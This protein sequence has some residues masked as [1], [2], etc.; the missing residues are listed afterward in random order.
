VICYFCDIKNSIEKKNLFP[1]EA[2][3]LFANI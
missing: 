2:Y 1:F 3:L